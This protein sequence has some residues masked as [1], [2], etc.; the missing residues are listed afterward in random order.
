[1]YKSFLKLFTGSALSQLCLLILIPLLSRLYGPV[2][3]GLV[4]TFSSWVILMASFSMCRYEHAVLLT[5]NNM[6]LSALLVFGIF[7]AIIINFIAFFFSSHSLGIYVGA[8]V[9]VAAVL[10]SIFNFAFLVLNKRSY[11][12]KMSVLIFLNP[13]V[14]VLLGFS[15]FSYFHSYGL[16]FARFLAY[17]LIAALCAYFCLAKDRWFIKVSIQDILGVLKKYRKFLVFALPGGVLNVASSQM[18]VI[19]IAHFFTLKQTAYYAMC[20]QIL[21]LPA[22]LVGTNMGSVFR[23]Q[24]VSAYKK[25]GRCYLVLK[26]TLVMLAVMGLIPFL[27]VVFLGHYI[28]DIYLG[29]K[30]AGIGWY[31]QIFAIQFYLAFVV[32]PLTYLVFIVNKQHIDLVWQ[33][34]LFLGILGSFFYGVYQGS[35]TLSFVCMVTTYSVMYVIYIPVLI[36]MSKNKLRL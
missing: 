28:F 21:A 10:Q 23:E 33:V 36:L 4:A 5:K 35:F 8:A 29:G 9:L 22:R 20:Y 7:S 1:M 19:L 11:Y 3:F 15:F 32:S 30:W 24:A 13:V 26:K 31:A 16:L 2:P 14:Y 18:P 34:L 6:E 25:T 17:F 12:N 27:V